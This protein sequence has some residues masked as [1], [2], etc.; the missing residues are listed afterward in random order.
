MKQ[1]CEL[2]I[3]FFVAYYFA[4]ITAQQR[5]NMESIYKQSDPLKISPTLFNG[6]I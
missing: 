6:D 4:L 5:W 3:Q 1:E 2:K